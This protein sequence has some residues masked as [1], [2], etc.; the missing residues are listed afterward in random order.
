[1]PILGDALRPVCNCQ[2]FITV[3]F[4]Q[5]APGCDTGTEGYFVGP[6]VSN[7]YL[8]GNALRPVCIIFILLSHVIYMSPYVLCVVLVLPV[9]Y[10][11]NYICYFIL[12]SVT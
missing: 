8:I 2:S 3:I 1:M 10:N 12:S 11:F 9:S 5:S 6:Q 7:T 4:C